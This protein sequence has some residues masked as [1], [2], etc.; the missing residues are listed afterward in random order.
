MGVC[1]GY[2]KKKKPL[3]KLLV[4]SHGSNKNSA[5]PESDL[6][7]LCLVGTARA[8][9]ETAKRS[10]RSWLANSQKC[11]ESPY[12]CYYNFSLAGFKCGALVFAAAVI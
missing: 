8:L 11:R 7:V 4:R 2:F 3:H 5:L 10:F 9:S 6:P 1:N 12:Y